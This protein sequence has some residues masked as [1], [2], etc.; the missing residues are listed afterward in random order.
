MKE[1]E[2][3]LIHCKTDVEQIS[4]ATTITA[5]RSKATKP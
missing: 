2:I 5:L 1:K 4:N 3:R